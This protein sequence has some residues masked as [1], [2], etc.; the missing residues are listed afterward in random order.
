MSVKFE[1]ILENILEKDSRYKEDAYAFVMDALSYSQ[2]KLKEQRHISGEELLKGIKE[3]LI[4]EFGPLTMAVLKHWGINSTEDFGNIVFNLV[5]NKVL[6]KTEDDDIDE[7]K[8]VFDFE[9]V[10]KRGYKKK[11]HRRISRMRGN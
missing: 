3:L 7:F 6:S 9:D 10:F 4:R 8:D 11:L 1:T 5:E 2:K